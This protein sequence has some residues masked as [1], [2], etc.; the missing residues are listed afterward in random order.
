MQLASQI[1]ARV[2][3]LYGKAQRANVERVTKDTT[4]GSPMHR[5]ARSLRDAISPSMIVALIALF[6]ALGGTAYATQSRSQNVLGAQIVTRVTASQAVKPGAA[7]IVV[8][9][10][11]RGY[12]AIGGGS[13]EIH[14]FKHLDAWDIVQ[15]GPVI[16]ERT[17]PDQPFPWWDPSEAGQSVAPQQLGA[18]RGWGAF[19]RNEGEGEGRFTVAA[20]CARV[21]VDQQ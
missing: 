11:P 16:A 2:K 18:A 13:Q 6:I 20:V 10:C 21:V 7:A 3:A 8:S 5:I 14:E 17:T 4:R 19:M 15:A 1:G 9:M 12:R